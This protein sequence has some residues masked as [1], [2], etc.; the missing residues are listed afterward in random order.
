MHRTHHRFGINHRLVR[1]HFGN[2]EISDFRI[3]IFINQNILRLDITVNNVMAVSMLQCIGKSHSDF[4][5]GI[6]AQLMLLHILLQSNTVNIF[7]NYILVAALRHNI[8]YVDDIR[9][10]QTRCGF[11]LPAELLQ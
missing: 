9:M 3:H 2:A 10:H 5:H 11:C 8:I 4:Q 1:D 6:Q 7:H